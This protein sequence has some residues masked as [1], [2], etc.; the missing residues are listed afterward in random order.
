MSSASLKEKMDRLQKCRDKVE[1]V[2]SKRSTISG[3]L[4][5]HQKRLVEVEK[6]CREEYGC[7]VAELPELIKQM[8]AEADKSIAEAERILSVPAKAEPAKV[9]PPAK[10]LTAPATVKRLPEPTDED[11]IP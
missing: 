10:K 3:E 4:S 11:A 8:E 7:E 5:G 6:K 9:E 2:K 1:S